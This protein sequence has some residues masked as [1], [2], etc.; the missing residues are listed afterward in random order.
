MYVGLRADEEERQ[1]IYS[2]DVTTDFPLRR[3]GWGLSQVVEYLKF[4]GVSIPERTDCAR[5]YDQRVYEWKRLWQRYPHLYA[6]A[7][8]QEAKTGKTF[9]SDA[10]DTWPANLAELRGEFE[11]GRK[12]QQEKKQELIQIQ[13]L[14]IPMFGELESGEEELTRCR[15]CRL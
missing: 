1:G 4:R 10:R 8:A 13:R 14:Q 15:V 9:R 7:E 6:E 3:W 2:N 5:C 11:K 12:T